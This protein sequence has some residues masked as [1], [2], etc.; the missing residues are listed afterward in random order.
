MEQ[1]EYWNR[2]G[3]A[4]ASLYEEP[5]WFNRVFRRG[6][7]LRTRMALAAVA[8]KPGASVL[9]VG[10]GNGRNSILIIKEAHAARV[11]G[12]DISS[13]MLA[14]ARELAK[15][16]E[17]AQQCTF[18]QGDFLQAPL[19]E[20]QF[21]YS[22]ALGLFDYFKDPLPV[23]A[24]IRQHTTVQCVASF[25]GYAIVRMA[26]RKIRYGARGCGVYCYSRRRI[27]DLYARAG[28]SSCR[29]ERCTRA[30]WMAFGSV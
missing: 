24:K 7:F 12:V 11:V 9:D 2:H 27:E 15:T 30:G 16:H 19:G 22:V 8:Q 17:V 21:D 1:Q 5:T 13:E 23:M 20:Q 18:I 28:F 10:C 25:P 4:F 14:S 3:L 29:I 26:L 6:M